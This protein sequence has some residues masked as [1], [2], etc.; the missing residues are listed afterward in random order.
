MLSALMKDQ[1]VRVILSVPWGDQKIAERVAQ[2]RRL[3]AEFRR[4]SFSSAAGPF[5]TLQPL[6]RAGFHCVD[7]ELAH[8]AKDLR[9]KS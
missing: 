1:K 7:R 5:A 6:Q 9:G 8:F 3:Y 4:T 2:D